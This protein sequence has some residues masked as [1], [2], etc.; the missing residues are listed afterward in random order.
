[1]K[2]TVISNIITQLSKL[3]FSTEQLEQIK[4]CIL[5][6]L[7][8]YNLLENTTSL[9]P[10]VRNSCLERFII[11]KKLEGKSENTLKNYYLILK[12]FFMELN[13]PV[14]KIT[15]DHIRYYLFKYQQERNI[16]NQSLEAMR[17][18]FSS[19]FHGV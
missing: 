8:N 3:D 2:D 13:L 7:T 12:N 9:T 17:R 16:T 14:E 4:E 19:F 6:N 15:T 1:M 18:I 10:C 11:S 5:F